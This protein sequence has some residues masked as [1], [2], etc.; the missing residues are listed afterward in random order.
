M[1]LATQVNKDFC[2][3]HSI[4]TQFMEKKTM[5]AIQI[6]QTGTTDVLNYVD[7]PTPKPQKGKVLIK[8]ES[9][10]VNYGD[11]AMR[12]GIY[13]QDLPFIP[14]VEY[15]G[16]IEATGADVNHNIRV[17]QSVV[18]FTPRNAYAEYIT[19]PADSIIPIPDDFDKDKAAAFPITYLTAYHLL[20][21]MA[22]VKAGQ[23]ILS[24]AAAGGVGT[25][26]NQLAQLADAKVIG[27]TSTAEKIQYLKEQG[28]NKVINYKTEDVV[29]RVKD[30]T[31]GR[32]VDVVLNS[33]AGDTL[34]R[35][36][37][38]LAPLGQ[39]LCYG[40]TSGPITG[41]L[42]KALTSDLMSSKGIRGFSLYTVVESKPQL[43]AESVAKVTQLLLENKIVP[44]IHDRIPLSE[45]ARAHQIMEAGKVCGKLI[46]K[47]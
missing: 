2:V 38:T 46:L 31:D 3:P 36:F 22:H 44:H 32:G 12:K 28:V 34:S 6:T 13:P 41:N 25:A 30:F 7:I 9:I 26:I 19:A 47:P 33:L 1:G 43:M 8:I 29:Q 45:V 24:Y 27:L 17:G 37:E 40:F 35:D 39:I 4:N 11:V 14:G 15:S 5:K 23:I 16:T 21:T 42:T 18:G 20:H 10:G